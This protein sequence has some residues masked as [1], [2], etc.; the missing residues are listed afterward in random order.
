MKK[1]Q[2]MKGFTLVELIVVVVIIAILASIAIPSYKR[3][4]LRSHRVEVRNILQDAAQKMQQ[5]YSISRS[6]AKDGS[7]N[8]IT[9]TSLGIANQSPLSGAVRYNITLQN[10]QNKFSLMAVAVY[11]QNEDDCK[12]FYIDQANIKRASDS[13]V[14]IGSISDNDFKGPREPLSIKCWAN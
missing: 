3:Y 10:K 11:P 9:L 6:Y 12:G 2:K 1:I 14:N 7:N 4:V 8:P 13:T 5:V